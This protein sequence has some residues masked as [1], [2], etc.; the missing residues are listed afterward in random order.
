MNFHYYDTQLL[1]ANRSQEPLKLKALLS[2]IYSE[3]QKIRKA[4]IS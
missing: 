3:R 2:V 4:F 1:N